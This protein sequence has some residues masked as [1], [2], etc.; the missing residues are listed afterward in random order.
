MVANKYP[1]VDRYLSE[2][3]LRKLNL[4]VSISAKAGLSKFTFAENDQT[5]EETDR[6]KIA[7]SVSK[8]N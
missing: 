6:R 3:I 2:T 7:R 8:C 1:S 5:Q 4:S